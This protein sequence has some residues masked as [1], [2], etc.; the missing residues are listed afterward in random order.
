MHDMEKFKH[1][2]QHADP[3]TIED[4]I[5]LAYSQLNPF[6]VKIIAQAK[7][8]WDNKSIVYLMGTSTK[9]NEIHVEV[10]AHFELIT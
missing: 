4:L 7:T 10:F 9:W 8:L 3:Q 5:T 1:F 6:L 2:F